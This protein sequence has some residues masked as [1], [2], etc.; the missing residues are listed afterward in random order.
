MQ[1]LHQ[2]KVIPMHHCNDVPEAQIREQMLVLDILWYKKSILGWFGQPGSTVKKSLGPI[3]SNF[4]DP[5]FYVFMGKNK[6]N[7]NTVASALKSCIE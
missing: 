6:F 7:E 1:A 4:G 2:T 3:M 5:F